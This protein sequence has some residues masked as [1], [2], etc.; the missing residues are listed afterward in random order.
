MKKQSSPLVRGLLIGIA[1]G[2]ILDSL[3]HN[4][5]QKDPAADQSE[6]I[7][8][9]DRKRI[10]AASREDWK[11]AARLRDI[12]NKMKYNGKST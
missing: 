6:S 11:E 10:I 3:L 2:L 12:I 5:S 8:S 4:R 7:A 9:L 1:A